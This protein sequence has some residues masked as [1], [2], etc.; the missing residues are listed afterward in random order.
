MRQ[1]SGSLQFEASLDH[2]L[3]PA[4][5]SQDP[6]PKN[7]SQK[8][9]AQGEELSSGPRTTKKK[10]WSIAEHPSPTPFLL[11]SMPFFKSKSF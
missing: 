8:G 4:N 3:K 10:D 1:R 6:I 11:S 9:L 7:P 5:N 2:N